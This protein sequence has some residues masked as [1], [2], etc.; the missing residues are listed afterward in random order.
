MVW[1]NEKK[2]KEV[3]SWMSE[4]GASEPGPG[5]E[6]GLGRELEQIPELGSRRESAQEPDREPELEE[7]RKPE[8]EPEQELEQEPEQEPELEA[9]RQPERESELRSV[10]EPVPEPEPATIWTNEDKNN[11]IKNRVHGIRP[12]EPGVVPELAPVLEPVSVPAPVSFSEAEQLPQPESESAE[13]ELQGLGTASPNLELFG[14]EA[15]FNLDILRSEALRLDLSDLE[16]DDDISGHSSPIHNSSNHDLDNECLIQTQQVV[17][18]DSIPTG[19][20]RGAPNENDM[21]SSLQVPELDEG[22]QDGM[23]DIFGLLMSP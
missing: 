4:M 5:Q 22:E 10:Q 11:E 21:E 13:V 16:D 17:V 12:G 7:G 6:R 19:E 2:D 20:C 3:N 23:E 8:Q 9:G 14:S 18:P 1:T 15:S